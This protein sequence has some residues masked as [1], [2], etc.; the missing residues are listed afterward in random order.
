MLEGT[1]NATS[2]TVPLPQGTNVA[3]NLA[4][5]VAVNDQQSNA[6]AATGENAL[7][8]LGSSDQPR[9]RGRPRKDRTISGDI[10]PKKEGGLQ[11][12]MQVTVFISAMQRQL[13]QKK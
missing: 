11:S 5:V 13:R 9:K 1:T 6:S 3:S 4:M 2:G 10:Q 7:I 12:K 8:C